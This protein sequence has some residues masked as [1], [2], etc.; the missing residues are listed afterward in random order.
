[1]ISIGFK[2]EYL[3]DIRHGIS[4]MPMG[5]CHLGACSLN[6]QT[7]GYLTGFCEDGCICGKTHAY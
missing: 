6:C 2:L 3:P 1:M 7:A 4:V 5:M